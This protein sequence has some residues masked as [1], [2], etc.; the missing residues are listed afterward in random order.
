MSRGVP[1]KEL[2]EN[3]FW[4]TGPAWLRLDPS[5]WPNE[6]QT[7]EEVPGQRKLVMSHLGMSRPSIVDNYVNLQDLLRATSSLFRVHQIIT[8]A[9]QDGFKETL[10]TCELHQALSILIKIS[11][12]EEFSSELVCLEKRA[13]LGAKNR[14][15]GLNPFIDQKGLL[16]VGGRLDNSDR[17]E[18]QQRPLILAPKHKLTKLI[19][20]AEHE[21]LLHAGPQLVLANLRLRYWIIRGRNEV[22]GVIRKC[23]SCSRVNPV[24]IMPQMGHLPADRTKRA[25]P[26][27]NSG[28]DYAGPIYIK[29]GSRRSKTTTKGYIAVFVCFCTKAIQLELVT[30]LTTAAFLSALRRFIARRGKVANLCSDNGT[31]FVGAAKEIQD[32]EKTLHSMEL[33]DRLS[34]EGIRWHFIPP[35]SP[36]FGGLWEAGVRSVKHHLRRVLGDSLLTFEEYY[37]VLTQIEACLNSR[38]ITYLSDDPADPLPLTPGHFLIG[39]PMEAPFEEDVTEVPDNRLNVWERLQKIKQHFW[40]R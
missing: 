7:P 20:V 19:I 34:M 24:S 32:L 28:V 27:L 5:C 15:L 40:K 14:L 18:D 33:K 10:S 36:H 11:Q 12:R 23:N 30:S 16:R 39:E 17:P 3:S 37:T 8:G 21:R 26:F 22:K 9:N 1:P 25:R 29:A 35:R 31:N 6:G 13:P 4:W 38:P 2:D